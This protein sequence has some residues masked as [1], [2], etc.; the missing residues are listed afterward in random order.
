MPRQKIGPGLS[1][2]SR[3]VL[4]EPVNND[5]ERLWAAY[6]AAQERSKRTLALSD[7][8]AAGRAYGAFVRAFVEPE[9]GRA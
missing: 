3:P 9:R 4:C 2:V 1:R 8:L 6:V 5:V 7:G